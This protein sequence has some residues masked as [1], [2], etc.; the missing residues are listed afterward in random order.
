[1][2]EVPFLQVGDEWHCSNGLPQK[3]IK[4]ASLTS[5]AIAERRVNR[6]S[7]RESPPAT[8]AI[9]V[10]GSSAIRE[11]PGLRSEKAMM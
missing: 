2:S 8:G 5:L 7:S 4:R 10:R 6:R 3:N 9:G 11:F 1:M